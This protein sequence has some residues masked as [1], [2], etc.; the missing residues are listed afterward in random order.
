MLQTRLA[1]LVASWQA[2]VG[3]RLWKSVFNFSVFFYFLD[4]S[5]EIYMWGVFVRGVEKRGQ[6]FGYWRGALK[7][8][9]LPFTSV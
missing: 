2:T 3:V 8:Q 1:Q 9:A 7:R 5:G 6:W 4:F